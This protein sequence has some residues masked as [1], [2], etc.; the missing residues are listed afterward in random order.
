MFSSEPVSRLSTQIT[1]W[2][3][4]EQVV[5]EMRAEE[6]GAAG[7]DGGC[8]RSPSY[9]RP[10]KP[11]SDPHGPFAIAFRARGGDSGRR[12][13]LLALARLLPPRVPLLG[14]RPADRAGPPVRR[15]LRRPA[16]PDL[17]VRLVAARDRARRE[18]ALHARGL[19]ADRRRPRLGEHRAA[20][21]GAVRAAHRARSGRSRPTTSRPC[22]SR[23]SR[24]GPPTSSAGTSPA[25]FWP[26]LVGGYLFGFSS[27][28]L[29]HVLG[30]PQLTAVFAIPL[31]ALVVVAG[32]RGALGRRGIVWRSA[33]CS[34]SSST[35]RWRSR[36][37]LT[38][39]LVLALVVGFLLAPPYRRPL[40]ASP[41]PAGDLVRC[42]RP[43]WPRR[44]STTR[45][46]ACASP[47][48]R[49]RAP[50]RPTS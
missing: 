50:T 16:D 20:G 30:Q 22:C 32:G 12:A 24:P 13:G 4:L 8:H 28:M 3:L 48:S 7:D 21:R 33:R 17:V 11:Q 45:S 44:S 31:I 26:S 27:Y 23:P 47:G 19:G 42:S 29:G 10:R 36:S 15:R 35:S 34:R 18:P 5:A 40:V 43:C 2:S 41:R 49:R 1:R 46:R 39:V 6:A 9:W 25:R 14:P 37:T 38:L